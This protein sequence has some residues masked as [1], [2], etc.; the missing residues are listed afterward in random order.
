[1]DIDTLYR[2]WTEDGYFD[3]QTK[4]ELL[5]LGAKEIEDRFYKALSFGTGGLRGLMGAGENRVNRYTVRK[6]SQGIADYINATGFPKGVSGVAI[7]CDTRRMSSQLAK[8]AASVFAANGIRV[9]LFAEAVPTPLLSYA[10][11]RLHCAF[12]VVI[13]AS[14]NPKEYNGYKVYG[15][16]GGQITDALAERLSEY[17]R[18][19][20]PVSAVKTVDFDTALAQGLIVYTGEDV[21]AAYSTDVLSLLGD[22]PQEARAALKIMYSPLHGAGLKT[23]ATALG[24]AGFANLAIVREQ[25][26][27]DGEFATVASPN[28]EEHEALAMAICEAQKNNAE[29]VIATDP[30]CDRLGIA[31]RNGAGEYEYLNGNQLGCLLL[32]QRLKNHQAQPGDYIVRTLVTTRMADAMASEAGVAIKE[33]LTG[34]KYIGEM[35]K[36][37]EQMGRFVFGFE[38]SYG[39]LAGTFVREKDA[40]IAALLACEAAADAKSKGM[41]LGGAMEALYQKYGYYLEALQSF[42]FYGREGGE[43]IQSLMRALRE[44]PPKTIAGQTITHAADY[45]EGAGNLPKS[46]VL[47]YSLSGGSWLA[48]RPSGTE[49]KLKI[50]MGA[51]GKSMQACKVMLHALQE[52]ANNL[53]GQS[54]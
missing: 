26:E 36:E 13:T 19:V 18:E 44:K 35:I 9:W 7:A 32:A 29:L 27:A 52:A 34:F 20:A 25:C 45:L 17:I 42:F 24:Q 48:V 53:I 1:M 33:V 46:D 30:D 21:A 54:V 51:V 38:E 11:R 41:D 22:V 50:Y 2:F 12:G 47:H 6:A 31:Y 10:V 3:A 14:H 23:V 15:S 39:V 28:P 5:A 40:V 37:L 43:K 49:P 8:E 16:D 4:N